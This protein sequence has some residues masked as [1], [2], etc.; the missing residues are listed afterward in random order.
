M[1]QVITGKSGQGRAFTNTLIF[2]KQ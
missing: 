2:D 1:T